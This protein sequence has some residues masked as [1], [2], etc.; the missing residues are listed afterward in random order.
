VASLGQVSWGLPVVGP[1]IATPTIVG[2]VVVGG[3]VGG[4]K[5]AITSTILNT[6]QG[7]YISVPTFLGSWT[8]C[9]STSIPM[10]FPTGLSQTN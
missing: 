2:G 5:G 10:N 8:G 4:A 7:S 1:F 3:L 6:I 9:L